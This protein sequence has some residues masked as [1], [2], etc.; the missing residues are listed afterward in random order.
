M[1]S[2]WQGLR[3]LGW[4]CQCFPRRLS[5]LVAICLSASSAFTLR[6]AA[7]PP[8]PE[9]TGAL[10]SKTQHLSIVWP[11][12]HLQLVSGAEVKYR[13]IWNYISLN[14]GLHYNHVFRRYYQSEI[15]IIPPRLSS[16]NA[17]NPKSLFQ[18]RKGRKIL[19][20]SESSVCC[21]CVWL[22]H[23]MINIASGSILTSK[24]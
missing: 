14:K 10:P 2:S 8:S 3:P 1:S 11:L 24:N 21:H 4:N 19:S 23:K 5:I 6:Q 17:S 22:K 20:L 9:D 15:I 13:K 16:S 12:W 7:H 18:S